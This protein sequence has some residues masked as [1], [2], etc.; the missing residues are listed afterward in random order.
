MQNKVGYHPILPPFEVDRNIFQSQQINVPKAHHSHP[1]Y[2]H[3][4]QVNSSIDHST[5]PVFL[6]GNAVCHDK[7]KKDITSSLFGHYQSLHIT[8]VRGQ[9]QTTSQGFYLSPYFNDNVFVTN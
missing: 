1:M 7:L 4:P 2:L 9:L 3:S 8:E 6:V 5:Y